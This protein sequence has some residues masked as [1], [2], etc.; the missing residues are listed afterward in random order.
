[1]ATRLSRREL[2]IATLIGE[3]LT[4]LRIAGRLNIAVRTV[5]SDAEHIRTKLRLHSRAQIAAWA[6]RNQSGGTT[7]EAFVARFDHRHGPSDT[8]HS[9]SGRR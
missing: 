3:G 5:D 9:G 1:M 6:V 2:T 4:S 7:H 8:S